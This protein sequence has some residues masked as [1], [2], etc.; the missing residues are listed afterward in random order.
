M[1][2]PSFNET[3]EVAESH[4]CC[5]PA[6]E[7]CCRQN[8]VMC[9]Y[10]CWRVDKVSVVRSQDGSFQNDL[11]VVL[12]FPDGFHEKFTVRITRKI[13]VFSKRRLLF[14]RKNKRCVNITWTVILPDNTRLSFEDFQCF[15]LKHIIDNLVYPCEGWYYSNRQVYMDLIKISP[16]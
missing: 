12:R 8:M 7:E 6:G 11:A 15:T 13:H 3:Y 5:S 10:N 4:P 9:R 2:L 16:R 14:F 1:Q